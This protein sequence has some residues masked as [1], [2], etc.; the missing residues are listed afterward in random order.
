MKN[1]KSITLRYIA[2]TL[3]FKVESHYERCMEFTKNF[4][5]KTRKMDGSISD[6]KITCVLR[7]T[8]GIINKRNVLETITFDGT[9]SFSYHVLKGPPGAYPV[10]KIFNGKVYNSKELKTLTD[11]ISRSFK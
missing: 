3:G 4:T 11:I 2:K 5:F 9:V 8:L 7:M 1:T 6:R 10:Q